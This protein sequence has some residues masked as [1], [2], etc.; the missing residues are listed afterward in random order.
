VLLS[1]ILLSIL[2]EK[3]ARY[4]LPMTIPLA[5]LLG[6]YISALM[7]SNGNANRTPRLLCLYNFLAVIFLSASIVTGIYYF[8]NFG[9]DLYMAL[10][11]IASLAMLIKLSKILLA[12]QQPDLIYIILSFIFMIQVAGPLA[13]IQIGPDDFMVFKKLRGLRLSTL[14]IYSGQIHMIKII[15]ACGRRIYQWK[16]GAPPKLEN[17]EKILLLTLADLQTTASIYGPKGYLILPEHEIVADN[18]NLFQVSQPAKIKRN[19]TSESL[20]NK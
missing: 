1:F 7:S 12:R 13:S 9:V 20:L 15:W 3:K 2:P 18:W 6:G 5:A 17:D 4:L 8:T 14:K 11:S 16:P 19:S 10:I